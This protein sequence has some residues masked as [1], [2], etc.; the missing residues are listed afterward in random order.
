MASIWAFNPIMVMIG[1]KAQVTVEELIDSLSCLTNHCTR[2]DETLLY[3]YCEKSPARRQGI[4][5]IT[6]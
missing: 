2:P 3:N 1:L 5:L 4:F 6:D